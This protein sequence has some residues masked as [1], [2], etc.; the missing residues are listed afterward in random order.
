MKYLKEDCGYGLHMLCQKKKKI[1][2]DLIFILLI[3]CVK[4]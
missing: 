2:N 3:Y 4:R 1:S